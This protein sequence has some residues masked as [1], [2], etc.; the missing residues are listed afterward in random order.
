MSENCTPIES[1]L[2]DLC[3][4]IQIIKKTF[5]LISVRVNSSTVHC[6]ESLAL[7]YDEL[8][9]VCSASPIDRANGLLLDKPF[10]IWLCETMTS[11]FQTEFVANHSSETFW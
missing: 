9:N 1:S 7:F 6:A 3:L 2:E 8:A 11:Y 4:N 10:L 5:Q